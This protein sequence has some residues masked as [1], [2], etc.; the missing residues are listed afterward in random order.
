MHSDKF[1]INGG[2]FKFDIIIIIYFFWQKY[3]LVWIYCQLPELLWISFRP[4]NGPAVLNYYRAAS[5]VN[6][7]EQQ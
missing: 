2:I 7:P 5:V 4:T 6:L 1:N 3:P